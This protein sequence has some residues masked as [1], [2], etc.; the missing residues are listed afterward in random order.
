MALFGECLTLQDFSHF[1]GP[2][3]QQAGWILDREEALLCIQFAVCGVCD[4]RISMQ[5]DNSPM[6]RMLYPN[7]TMLSF[8]SKS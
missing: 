1:P 2:K 7:D 4:R 8:T 5:N 3:T 6:A